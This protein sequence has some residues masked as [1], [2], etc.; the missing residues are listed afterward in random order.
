MCGEEGDVWETGGQ[1]GDM[2]AIIDD[3]GPQRG[4]VWQSMCRNREK[5]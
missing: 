4:G 2:G 3:S 1:P 5:G